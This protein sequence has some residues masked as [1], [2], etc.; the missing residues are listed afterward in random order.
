MLRAGF[1]WSRP[2]MI[3]Y[4]AYASMRVDGADVRRSYSICAGVDDGDVVRLHL[5]SREFGKYLDAEY[6]STRAVMADL[7]LA[8]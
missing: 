7:G 4:V 5:R 3:W 1:E 2:E 8:K 6:Q